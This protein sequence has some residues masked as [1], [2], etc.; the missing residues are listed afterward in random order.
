MEFFKYLL[1]CYFSVLGGR[2][3]AVIKI[4][5]RRI[6]NFV[7]FLDDIGKV[8]GFKFENFIVYFLKVIG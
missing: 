3:R 7:R 5:K 6:Y 1:V 4:E 8:F 2:K